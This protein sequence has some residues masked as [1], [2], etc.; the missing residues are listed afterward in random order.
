[1]QPGASRLKQFPQH[2]W[3]HT[4]I[5]GSRSGLQVKD[6]HGH[7]EEKFNQRPQRWWSDRNFSSLWKGCELRLFSLGKR[8]LL[9]GILSVC[10]NTWREGDKEDRAKLFPMVP[11]HGTKLKHR[12]FF[13]KIRKHFFILRLTKHQYRLFREITESP[14]LENI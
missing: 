6:R 4:W 1:M 13:P 8:R 2:R 11:S 5:T 14:I 12:R 7:P 3:S 10:R 9:G